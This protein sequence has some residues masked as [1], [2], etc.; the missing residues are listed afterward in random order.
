MNA[1]LRLVLLS[2]LFCCASSNASNA[3]HI[4]Q[5]QLN[6]AEKQLAD[7]IFRDDSGREVYLR[8]WNV[9]GSVKLVSHGFK[10]FLSA[11]DAARSFE[12]MKRHTGANLV[13]FTLSWEGTHPAPDQID[14]RYL[15]ALIEQMREAFKQRIYL[16]LDFHTDLFSRHL[17]APNSPFT[18]NGAPEWVVRGAGYSTMRCSPHCFVWGQAL[19]S[20][21]EIRRAY[22]DFFDNTIIQT[23]RGERRVQDEYLWQL[24]R[25]IRYI[26]SQLTAEEFDWILG[27]EPINEPSYG[28]GHRDTA[29]YF[30]NEKLWP[31][32]QR[33]RAVLN[34]HG[35]QDKWVFAGPSLF[36]D[37]NAGYFL[38]PT[39][40]GHLLAKPG[41]GFVFA[42]HFYDAAR[43]GL[44]NLNRVHN[45]EYFKHLDSIRQEA[46]FL[47]MPAVLGE[48]G[49][50]LKNQDG[51]VRDYARV[52]H[53]VYQALESSDRLHTEKDRR[54]DLHTSFVAS[55]QWHWDIYKDQHAEYQNGNLQKLKT[56][57][58]GWNGEDFSAVKGET[59]S[60][61]AD[62]IMRAYP[63]AVD[64][65]LVSFYY[66]GL[67]HDGAGV[68]L[69]WA[70]IRTA[71]A[72]YFA[73]TRFS[74]LIWQ[75]GSGQESEIFLPSSFDPATCVLLTDQGILP[76]REWMSAEFSNGVTGYRL[77]VP[78]AA[79]SAPDRFHF[80]LAV[81]HT[82]LDAA[83]LAQLQRELTEQINAHQ[84]PVFWRGRMKELN[85]PADD[86]A[87]EAIKLQATEQQ[88]LFWRW[89]TLNWQSA[90]PVTVWMNDEPVRYG[91]AN[92]NTT[93]LVKTGRADR[94]Q[95]CQQAASTHCSRTLQFD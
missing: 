1:P 61:N 66:N 20:S 60:V 88:I 95:V 38:P 67:P 34:Q 83:A 90:Q 46:A 23:V 4:G 64:G 63:R 22:K 93:L 62:V 54:P 49:M 65:N 28:E 26:K 15:D 47:G 14:Y 44:G 87:F 19:L 16:F 6:L 25:V 33:V 3:L 13:R 94:L 2:L 24:Q 85:Q 69:D 48:F 68:L 82:A 37:T 53:G 21:P 35:W 79:A 11:Q 74:L 45:G 56:Q 55:T 12:L 10:P 76:A 91:S 84:H 52:V 86:G 17:F 57:G 5:R 51:G 42:P 77:R 30:D 71:Q 50:W 59:L 58:D 70:E 9:S 78:G 41:T 29:A 31:F 72:S 73:D 18:G 7:P 27:I 80:I 75:G 39:G 8:G 32:Y 81:Q 92:G 36:W 89:V 43:M 40:G